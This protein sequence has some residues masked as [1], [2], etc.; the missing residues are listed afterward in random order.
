MSSMD[1]D[2]QEQQ[3]HTATPMHLR[4]LESPVL[5]TI[6]SR[7]ESPQST[8]DQPDTSTMPTHFSPYNRTTPPMTPRV[9]DG[10][11]PRS[12]FHSRMPNYTR[13]PEAA[14]VWQ[15]GSVFTQMAPPGYGPR[16]TIGFAK[17]HDDHFNT[18]HPQHP[19]NTPSTMQVY[20]GHGLPKMTI[21]KRE[22]PRIVVP[23][24]GSVKLP[25]IS[26]SELKIPLYSELE[27]KPKK[28]RRQSIEKTQAWL[29]SLRK[30]SPGQLFNKNFGFDGASLWAPC[31]RTPQISPRSSIF[32]VDPLSPL[33]SSAA[34]ER[35]DVDSKSADTV[36]DSP[37]GKTTTPTKS[38]P[39]APPQE[40]QSVSAT[41]P[42]SHHSTSDVH[43]GNPV[44]WGH[45]V[46]TP[47][48]HTNPF[49]LF[50]P[51]TTLPSR[52]HSFPST[53]TPS[54]HKQNK[55]LARLTILSTTVRKRACTLGRQER[56]SRKVAPGPGST[57]ATKAVNE[58]DGGEM[59]TLK[60]STSNPSAEAFLKHVRASLE[61]RRMSGG[62]KRGEN[63]VFA[64]EAEK[65][66]LGNAPL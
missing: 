31:D 29:A 19:Y 15:H 50:P 27:H 28:S 46:P 25:T 63:A 9:H 7:V 23:G 13:S 65:G 16:D 38:T 3:I 17:S 43:P 36:L 56:T 37:H 44:D 4:K 62:G 2:Y 48:I 66:F 10:S 41:P 6:P 26:A 30:H 12:P 54:S 24:H 35:Q 32:K 8:R 42:P 58:R 21:Q 64:D 51:P 57:P 5:Q 53:C 49:T 1:Q 14:A 40:Q 61:R 18:S 20:T 47:T 45:T 22:V 11:I 52:R 34:V 33:S 59:T 39:A 55:H 60:R